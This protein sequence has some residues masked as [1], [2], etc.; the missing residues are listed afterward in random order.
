MVE[1]SA[2]TSAT[3]MELA[4]SIG[5]GGRV[6]RSAAGSSGSSPVP[7]QELRLNVDCWDLDLNNG[8]G[9]AGLLRCSP[10]AAAP[11]LRE[12]YHAAGGATAV[13]RPVY[14]RR[15]ANTMESR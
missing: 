13:Y 5:R 14:R 10:G 12:V 11:H 4:C 7:A 15:L 6:L 8:H 1:A 3:R 9:R 2:S